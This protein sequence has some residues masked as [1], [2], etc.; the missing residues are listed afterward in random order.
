MFPHFSYAEFISVMLAV[1]A[2]GQI[3]VINFCAFSAIPT[4]AMLTLMIESLVYNTLNYYGK[5][6]NDKICK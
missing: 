6:A 4:A 5:I 1:N 2:F 3:A